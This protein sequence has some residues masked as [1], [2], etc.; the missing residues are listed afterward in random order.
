MQ[1]TK[2]VA[3]I[4]GCRAGWCIATFYNSGISMHIAPNLHEMVDI[5]RDAEIALIDIPLGL[6]DHQFSRTIETSMRSV[7][8]PRKKSSVF[9]PPCREALLAST[10]EMAKKKNLNVTG[11]KIS[12]QSFYIMPKIREADDLLN[13]DRSLICLLDT[14]PSPRD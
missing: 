1:E 4:D 6:T 9:T 11:K 10:F 2:Q 3:G 12:L 7:L 5:I 8:P 13:S 14:S